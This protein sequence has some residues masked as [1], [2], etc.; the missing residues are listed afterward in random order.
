MGFLTIDPEEL[1]FENVQL[2]HAYTQRIIISNPHDAPV[3]VALK[4]SAASR[5]QISPAG[6]LEIPARGQ[7]TVTIRLKVDSFP[8]R[9][10]GTRGQRDS[11][12]LKGAFFEQ[13][14]FSTFYLQKETKKTT[15]SASTTSTTTRR[16]GKGETK[17]SSTATSK[18]RNNSK[19]A[20]GLLVSNNNNNNNAK[21]NSDG[22]QPPHQVRVHRSGS[23][24]VMHNGNRNNTDSDTGRGG[25]TERSTG[26]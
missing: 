5:Y 12:Q 4:C 9:M 7:V 15:A 19:S 14:F 16:G 13:K 6:A 10:R 8:N 24:S 25:K 26:N 20:T 11:F 21:K 17:S 3:T 18:R 23:V 1:I 22:T 2:G